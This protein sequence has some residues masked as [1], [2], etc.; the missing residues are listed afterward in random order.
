MDKALN[1]LP[2][3]ASDAVLA[4][5]PWIVGERYVLRN[6]LLDPAWPDRLVE[7]EPMRGDPYWQGTQHE[8]EQA[9]DDPRQVKVRAVLDVTPDPRTRQPRVWTPELDPRLVEQLARLAR[10]P[11]H[12]ILRWVQQNGFL[13]LRSD[14]AKDRWHPTG[15][16][17]TV[18]EI[19]YAC[20]RL[21]QGWRLARL[22]RR[23]KA[24]G[25]FAAAVEILPGAEYS[26][27]EGA[28]ERF[29]GR[30]VGPDLARRFGLH[31]SPEE[32]SGTAA[33]ERLQVAY[34]LLEVLSDRAFRGLLRVGVDGTPTEDSAGLR[35]RPTIQAVGP[36]ATAYLQM[37]E[38][39]SWPAVLGRKGSQTRM[40]FWKSSRRCEYC[41]A[42]YRPGRRKQRWCS[43]RCREAG[44]HDRHRPAG[45]RPR[46]RPAR[47]G[48]PRSTAP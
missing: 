9:R 10:S 16:F 15:W 44:W 25:L 38:A 27:R 42:I 34:L 18:E 46:R 12:E 29:G 8:R 36:F 14:A 17:E 30:L 39:V 6:G 26:L 1:Q 23:R 13:G 21:D 4:S 48:R 43:K 24:E 20:G 11:E 3:F 35:L 32:I 7:W 5:S 2:A 40:L 33:E 31:A 47:P 45:V 37:L 28:F 41:G 22:L 19:R